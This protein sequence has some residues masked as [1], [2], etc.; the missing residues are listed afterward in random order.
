VTGAA[1]MVAP[2]SFFDYQMFRTREN[3]R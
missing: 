1:V 2:N 3:E